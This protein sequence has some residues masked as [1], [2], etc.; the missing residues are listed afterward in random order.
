MN[1]IV[2]GKFSY[3]IGN[4]ANSYIL[5]LRQIISEANL[6][7]IKTNLGHIVF[8]PVIIS[9]EFPISKKSARSYSRKE[10]TEFINTEIQYYQ[11][12]KADDQEKAGLLL[13]SLREAIIGTKDSKI[14]KAS[15][16][17]ILERVFH[18]SLSRPFVPSDD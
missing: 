4:E 15:K 12:V 3:E 5:W 16:D 2:S 18:A 8:F 10:D 17:E 9:D 14:E 7:N 6:A 11:W 13:N 1:I